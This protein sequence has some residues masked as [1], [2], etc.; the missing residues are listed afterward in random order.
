MSELIYSGTFLSKRPALSAA[1]SFAHEA[2]WQEK[3]MFSKASTRSLIA[4]LSFL[5]VSCSCSKDYIYGRPLVPDVVS[6]NVQVGGPDGWHCAGVMVRSGIAGDYVVTAK[7]CVLD[8]EGVREVLFKVKVDGREFWADLYSMHKDADVAILK[9][10]GCYITNPTA[11]IGKR[12]VVGQH[13]WAI[14]NPR[15]MVNTVSEGIV[16]NLSEEGKTIAAV[17]IFFGN[18]GGG[19][20]DDDGGLIGIASSLI[21]VPGPFGSPILSGFSVFVSYDDLLAIL[22]SLP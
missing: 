4:I 6:A 11:A 1:T 22:D 19:L 2:G 13:V 12:P 15:G 21:G 9:L 5:V 10:N 14:G 7:H 8:D 16:S 17:T 3:A 20:F 18:S